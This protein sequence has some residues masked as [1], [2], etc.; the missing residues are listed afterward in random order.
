M[1]ENKNCPKRYKVEHFEQIPPVPCPCGMS[2][3]AFIGFDGRATFH[4]VDIKKDAALHYHKN[5]YEI[6]L[7]LEG[8]GHMELDGEIIPVEQGSTIF[9]QEYCRHRALG[10]MKIVNVSVPAFDP[11]DEYFD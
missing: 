9:L 2:R 6:Y 10:E 4:Q 1:N 8:K 3:R 11:A 7:I 5:H